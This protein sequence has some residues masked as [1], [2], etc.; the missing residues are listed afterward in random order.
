MCGARLL[1]DWKLLLL[2]QTWQ[3][4]VDLRLFLRKVRENE[5][6]CISERLVKLI[7]NLQQLWHRLL[8]FIIDVVGNLSWFRGFLHNLQ[9]LLFGRL[10]RLFFLF[11]LLLFYLSLFAVDLGGATT[12]FLQLYLRLDNITDLACLAELLHA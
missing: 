12:L 3:V 4:L 5:R 7:R 1:S 6:T 8:L 9:F 11:F 2:K 10:L